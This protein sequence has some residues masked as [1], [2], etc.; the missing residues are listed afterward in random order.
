MHK[1][2]SSGCPALSE[3][4][5]T[6]FFYSERNKI[7][8]LLPQRVLAPAHWFTKEDWEVGAAIC[9]Q[10][11]VSNCGTWVGAVTVSN[12]PAV[13]Q[14]RTFLGQEKSRTNS[15]VSQAWGVQQQQKHRYWVEET[16][17]CSP[18]GRKAQVDGTGWHR[19]MK[20]CFLPD[21]CTE[22]VLLKG[23]ILLPQA[24]SLNSG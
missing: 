16:T 20:S 3:I 18:T 14:E 13:A 17:W 22:K 10:E 11:T 24:G 8:V 9:P 2:S 6:F 7:F 5:C 12:I 4:S 15:D 23:A 21:Q 1:I 19:L